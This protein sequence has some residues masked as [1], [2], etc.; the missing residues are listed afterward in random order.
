MKERLKIKLLAW[1][2]RICAC[3][4]LIGV[5]TAQTSTAQEKLPNT[6]K[7]DGSG[8][9]AKTSEGVVAAPT[10]KRLAW[11]NHRLRAENIRLQLDALLRKEHPREFAQLEAEDKAAD[12]ELEAMQKAVGA[13]YA[14]RISQAGLIEF[15]LKDEERPASEKAAVKK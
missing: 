8:G 9:I 13:K 12:A 4:L 10:E 7:A 15:Y 5:L 1:L 2:A 6:A 11:E 3:L 14:P